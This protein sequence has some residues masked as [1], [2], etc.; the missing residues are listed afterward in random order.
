M[1]GESARRIDSAGMMTI[2]VPDRQA[3]TAEMEKLC[4][5]IA[6]DLHQVCALMK[7]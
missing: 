3:A 5:Y 1:R 2:M 4:V 6:Q 7:S